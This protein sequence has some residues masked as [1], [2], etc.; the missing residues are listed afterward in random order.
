MTTFADRSTYYLIYASSPHH[1]PQSG[2]F[3]LHFSPFKYL[4][5]G[6]NIN[7]LGRH[8]LHFFA[9]EFLCDLGLSSFHVE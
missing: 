3:L 7:L 9:F 5:I 1:P 2:H 4:F 8:S 6:A